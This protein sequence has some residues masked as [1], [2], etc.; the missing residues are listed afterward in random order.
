MYSRKRG[1]ALKEK[2]KVISVVHRHHS[3][4]ELP[5]KITRAVSHF[6]FVENK[7]AV[8]YFFLFYFLD[9]FGKTKWAR[10]PK[11]EVSSL[12]CEENMRKK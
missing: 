10:Q 8:P 5:K 2:D 12:R 9:N 6:E 11:K 4:R 1:E 7:C 3:T